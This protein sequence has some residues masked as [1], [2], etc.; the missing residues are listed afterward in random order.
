V[1]HLAGGGAGGG[2]GVGQGMGGCNAH[3]VPVTG[4]VELLGQRCSP[5]TPKQTRPSLVPHV[6]QHL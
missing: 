4:S 6:K 3:C 1:Q 2:V 5:Q